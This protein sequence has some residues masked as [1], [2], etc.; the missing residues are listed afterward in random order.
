M[1]VLII[2]IKILP[3]DTEHSFFW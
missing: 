3:E 1:N 2:A